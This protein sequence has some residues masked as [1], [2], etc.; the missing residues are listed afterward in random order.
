MTSLWPFPLNIGHV[1]LRGLGGLLK[2]RAVEIHAPTMGILH[3]RFSAF[4]E[5]DGSNL[6]PIVQLYIA[7]QLGLYYLLPFFCI[8]WFKLGG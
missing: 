5:D 8:V 7:L 3:L 1:G 4:A 6:P 2:Q